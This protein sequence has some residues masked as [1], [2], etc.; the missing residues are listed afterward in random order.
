MHALRVKL[1][2]ISMELSSSN[3]IDRQV[4]IRSTWHKLQS[5]QTLD[6]NTLC[7][8]I[9]HRHAISKQLSSLRVSFS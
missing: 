5:W 8:Y 9:I 4:Y 2:V 7:L 6:F 3:F 1:D